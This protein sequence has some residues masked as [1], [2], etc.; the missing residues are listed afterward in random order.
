MNF[1]QKGRL[2]MLKENEK[3]AVFDV[4]VCHKVDTCMDSLAFLSFIQ[5][6][7]T[8]DI[9]HVIKENKERLVP[10]ETSNI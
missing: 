6:A 4:F 9:Y 5:E 1:G 7:S 8:S 2:G 10:V 3:Q